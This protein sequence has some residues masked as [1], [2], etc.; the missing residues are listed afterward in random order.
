MMIS[1]H[2]ITCAAARIHISAAAAA[3][4]ERR[5]E[6]A[7][8]RR[9][10]SRRIRHHTG[11]RVLGLRDRR[12]G[13]GAVPVVVVH[14]LR[15]RRWSVVFLLVR[16]EGMERRRRRCR[17]GRGRRLFRGGEDRGAWPRVARRVAAAVAHRD[18]RVLLLRW[19]HLLSVLLRGR[20]PA[21]PGACSS[22]CS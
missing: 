8:R 9:R 18:A 10:G 7:R 2:H 15:R 13:V 6:G 5:R 19:R 1:Y 11:R 16:G 22:G 12:S 3:L 20:R 21:A 17:A 14:D 4:A